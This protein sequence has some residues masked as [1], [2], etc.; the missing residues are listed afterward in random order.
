MLH[1]EIHVIET[2]EDLDLALQSGLLNIGQANG[3]ECADCSAELGYASLD[4]F[5][6]FAVIINEHDQ[7]WQICTE[8]AAPV[9]DGGSGSFYETSYEDLQD[10]E[11]VGPVEDLDYF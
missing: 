6:P 9:I 11:I 7:D 10:H 1:L 4:G 2:E 8:C 3:T 5:E